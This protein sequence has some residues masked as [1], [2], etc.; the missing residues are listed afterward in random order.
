MIS[1]H[2]REDLTDIEYRYKATTGGTYTAWTSVTESFS[3]TG[4]TFEI[5]GLTNG[6]D[7]T[8]QV[9]GVNDSGD[10]LPS[11][12]ETATPDAPPKITGVAITS[13]PGTDKTYAIDDDIVVTFTFDKNITLSGTGFP[14]VATFMI[15]TESWEPDCAVG[16]APTMVMTCTHTVAAGDEDTD[17]IEV[18]GN[19][20]LEAQQRIVG[21]LGQR[22][23][24]T[25]SALAEDSDHKVDGVRP[26]LTGARA[27]ADKT[28]IT[29][30]FSEAI[31]AVDRTKI[32]F[33]SGGTT[34]THTADSTTG[35]EVEIT[36]TNRR[37]EPWTPT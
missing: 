2:G 6:T 20:I 5:G 14:P 16:T 13:A 36:L 24:L 35:A 11:S 3:N 17:G 29:L 30:T 7:Y 31:G 4:G 10:G 32:T 28:K 15:G 12:E 23:V 1:D 27:S 21:P 22:A 8:V 9:Q 19:G 25:H 26:E 37:S 34:L 18:I 33:D